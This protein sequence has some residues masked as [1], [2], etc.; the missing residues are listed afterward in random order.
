MK[1][2]QDELLLNKV[3]AW[4]S[5]GKL[6]SSLSSEHQNLTPQLCPPPLPRSS[7][8][9]RWSECRWRLTSYGEG[10][11]P[12]IPGE[13]SP[14]VLSLGSP[15]SQVHPFVATPYSQLLIPYF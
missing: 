12:P 15:D 5:V 13:G 9:P 1:K 3:G 7:S 6:L 10:H 14:P 4:D 8:W 2:L 11:P